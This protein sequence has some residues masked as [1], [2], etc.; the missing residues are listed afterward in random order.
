ML[1]R[2]KSTL[3]ICKCHA[4]L[5][6]A[7]HRTALSR[8]EI[9]TNRGFVWRKGKEDEKSLNNHKQLNVAVETLVLVSVSKRKQTELAY[10]P[11][12]TNTVYFLADTL[13]NTGTAG[14]LRVGGKKKKS[15]TAVTQQQT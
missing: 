1:A 4:A 5:S 10:T 13:N 15:F 8:E 6:V 7:N 12:Y 2:R 9:R 3:A 14:N 11:V